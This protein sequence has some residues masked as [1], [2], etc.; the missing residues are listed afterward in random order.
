MQKIKNYI[1]GELVLPYND[2]YIDNYNPST[3]KVYSLIPD[4]DQ[5]DVDDAVEAAK[6]AF[7]EWSAKSK[8][9][10]S[11]LL[12]RISDLIIK[13]LDRLAEAESVDN[14]KPL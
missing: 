1:N 5:Q 8:E 2:T 11:E 10:R 9:K 12:M 6:K 3:G 4:S 7:P 13:N 14:G